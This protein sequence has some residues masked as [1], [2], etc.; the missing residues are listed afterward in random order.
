MVTTLSKIGDQHA[1][2]LDPALLEEAGI[3]P[4]TP[5]DVS[6]V[7]GAVVVRPARVGLDPKRFDEIAEHV[8]DRFDNA[9]RRL[10][11]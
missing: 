9:F 6:M 1:V 8:A 3:T 4:D 7:D 11:E 10:A 2:I 5:L